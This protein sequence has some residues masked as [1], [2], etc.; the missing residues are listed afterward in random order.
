MES[1]RIP[2]TNTSI[3]QYNHFGKPPITFKKAEEQML[4]III[5]GRAFGTVNTPLRHPHQSTWVQVMTLLWIP[6]FCRCTPGRQQVQWLKYLGCCFSS[7][8]PQLCRALGM[9]LQ[10]GHPSIHSPPYLHLSV[11]TFQIK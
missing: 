9:N 11:P 7:V 2:H 1:N 3:N 4:T 6:A 8:Q 5:K 10:M